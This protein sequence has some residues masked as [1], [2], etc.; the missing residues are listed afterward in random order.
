MLSIIN[1]VHNYKS[2]RELVTNVFKGTSDTII[3][4]LTED[5]SYHQLLTDDVNYNLCF[6]IDGISS[7]DGHLIYELLNNIS[8]L[9][10]IDISSIKLTKSVKDTLSYHVVIPSIHATLTTQN[11]LG[12][13]LKRDFDYIDLCVYQNNRWF[14]LPNQTNIEKPN[15]HI[16]ISGQMINFVLD[17]IQPSSELINIDTSINTKKSIC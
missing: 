11:H 14:R 8:D 4:A 3:T 5:K 12:K 2:K 10:N 16:F 7:T 15:A 9:F 13:Q 17:I 6:D 1:T